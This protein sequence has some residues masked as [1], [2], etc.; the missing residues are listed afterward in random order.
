MRAPFLP[1]T[2]VLSTVTALETIH[3]TYHELELNTTSRSSSTI[4]AAWYT[5]W[6]ATDF[7]LSQ[8]S[9]SKYTNLIYAF[10]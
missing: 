9:W 6:H 10:A 4:S 7:P 3:P 8:V 2:L 1:L 5:G